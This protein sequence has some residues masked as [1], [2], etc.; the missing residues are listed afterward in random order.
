VAKQDLT[1]LTL[2]GP[3]AW[4]SIRFGSCPPLRGA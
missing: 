2:L 3:S 1:L 4:L